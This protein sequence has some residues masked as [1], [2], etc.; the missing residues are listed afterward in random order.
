MEII[1]KK[2]MKS[3]VTVFTLSLSFIILI[4]LYGMSS[5]REQNSDYTAQKTQSNNTT[6]KSGQ[7]NMPLPMITEQELQEIMYNAVEEYKRLPES[8]KEMM[9][10]SF[11]IDRQELDDIMKEAEQMIPSFTENTK[12]STDTSSQTNENIF[13]SENGI[14]APQKS[15]Q[16][17]KQ[18]QNENIQTIKRAVMTLQI[19]IAKMKDEYIRDTV[20]DKFPNAYELIEITNYYLSIV[21]EYLKD[22]ENPIQE[23]TELVIICNK[24]NALNDAITKIITNEE[25]TTI[26]QPTNLFSKYSIKKNSLEKLASWI[27]S[28]IKTTKDKIKILEEE[29]EK[30]KQKEIKKEIFQLEFKLDDLEKD[31]TE[32]KTQTVKNKNINETEKYKTIVQ[33]STDSI[34]SSIKGILINDRGIEIIEKIIKKYFPEE[35]KIGKKKEQ[36]IKNQMAKEKKINEQKGSQG[37]NNGEKEQRNK[38]NDRKED[39]HSVDSNNFQYQPTEN[40]QDQYGNEKTEDEWNF[41]KEQNPGN[42]KTDKES[43]APS[44]QQKDTGDK[45]DSENQTRQTS[46]PSRLKREKEDIKKKKKEEKDITQLSKAL[47]NLESDIHDY[48]NENAENQF[49]Q[50]NTMKLQ[51]KIKSNIEKINKVTNQIDKKNILQKSEQK[52]MLK[53]EKE[54]LPSNQSHT[55]IEK[56]KNKIKLLNLDPK[57]IEY[58]EGQHI[59]YKINKITELMSENFN[60]EKRKRVY[61]NYLKKE[62]EEI[63]DTFNAI[64]NRMHKILTKMKLDTPFWLETLENIEKKIEQQKK[65][66]EKNLSTKEKTN[67]QIPN[68]SLTKISS[69]PNM[70]T[71]VPTQEISKEKFLQ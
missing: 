41:P 57:T 63:S 69:A 34:A 37:Q 49:H 51:E 28:E 52:N 66:T 23:V 36:D 32:L 43:G 10:K 16:K 38:I 68:P 46:S 14:Q 48:I 40:Y 4:E 33:N 59:T 1:Q 54:N 2:I 35:Y 67:S 12:K 47:D 9:C 62:I 19:L 44:I 71:S 25:Y 58:G 50:E 15:I 60:S 24:I 30:N 42:S 13:K 17:A 39:S 3:I 61:M 53:E 11:G 20:V 26:N 21:A 8:E 29:Y 65:E 64:K 31:F 56:E 18:T 5:T 6:K 70:S 7:G 27:E 22:K 55:F 45:A